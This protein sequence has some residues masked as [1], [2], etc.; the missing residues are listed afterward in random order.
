MIP[1]KENA[2]EI[3]PGKTV[4][5][6]YRVFEAPVA[7]AAE[8]KERIERLELHDLSVDPW[9]SHALQLDIRPRNYSR[10]SETTDGSAQHVH[11]LFGVADHETVVR[12]MQGDLTNVGAKA[13]RAMMIF[14]VNIIGDR[15]ADS[16]KTSSR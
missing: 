9:P 10:Q 7:F 12:T 8:L 13:S 15:P 3:L 5:P 16:N 11:I 6:G 1:A 4:K 14:A 2:S